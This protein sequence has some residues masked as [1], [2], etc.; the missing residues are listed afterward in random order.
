MAVNNTVG[1]KKY[2]VSAS[3]FGYHYLRVTKLTVSTLSTTSQCGYT[4]Y[5]D[6]QAIAKPLHNTGSN[7]QAGKGTRPLAINEQVKCTQFNTSICQQGRN[8]GQDLSTVGALQL[9]KLF[10]G[11]VTQAQ[12][13]AT[14]CGRS[15]DG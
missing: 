13:Q 12:A 11:L 10:C 14:G 3:C 2:F 9:Y 15:F 7:T 8:P 1:A 4:H 6:I 5:G